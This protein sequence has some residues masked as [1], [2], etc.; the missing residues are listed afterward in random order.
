MN[1]DVI[2]QE[3]L[4]LQ[5]KATDFAQQLPG[6]VSECLTNLVIK[7]AA[8]GTGSHEVLTVLLAT[9]PWSVLSGRLSL[10][11]AFLENVA[12]QLEDEIIL[13]DEISGHLMAVVFGT[14]TTASIIKTADETVK[15][16]HLVPNDS[17]SDSSNSRIRRQLL[18]WDLGNGWSFGPIGGLS[19]RDRTDMYKF[20]VRPTFRGF[21]PN[22]ISASFRIRF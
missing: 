9:D 13:S 18:N 11:L 6:D 2:L 3:V 7:M 22:G 19:W 14:N 10:S 16:M 8:T 20:N 4:N 12:R 21:E 1:L 5:A 15:A 17:D